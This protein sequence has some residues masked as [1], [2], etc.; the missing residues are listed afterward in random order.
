[1]LQSEYYKPL[2]VPSVAARLN[3]IIKR[4]GKHFS[5]EDIRLMFHALIHSGQDLQSIII[6]Q[7]MFMDNYKHKSNNGMD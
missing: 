5:S 1:M 6:E 3:R 4:A 7:R 2:Q